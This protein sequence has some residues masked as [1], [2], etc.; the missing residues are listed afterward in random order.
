MVFAAVADNNGPFT[1]TAS[2][3]TAS[4]F[5]LDQNVIKNGGSLAD[6]IVIDVVA[7]HFVL[8]KQVLLPFVGPVTFKLATTGNNP[9]RFYGLRSHIVSI[10]SDQGNFTSLDVLGIPLEQIL[11]A[12]FL[13]HRPIQTQIMAM[14]FLQP[15]Q[16]TILRRQCL[17]TLTFQCQPICT[18]PRSHQSLRSDPALLP[19]IMEQ[20]RAVPSQPVHHLPG[21]QS[22]QLLATLIPDLER[23]QRQCPRWQQPRLPAARLQSQMQPPIQSYLR[24]SVSSR[25]L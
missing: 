13:P 23:P 18:L 20:H 11:G 21:H 2:T 19:L 3:F 5:R 12:S 25:S 14:R 8:S 6:A 10:A 24:I 16:A 15:I 22:N 1:I 4:N 17:S 9:V 7:T